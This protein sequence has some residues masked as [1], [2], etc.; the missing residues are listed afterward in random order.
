[1]AHESSRVH[2]EIEEDGRMLAAGVIERTGEDQPRVSVHREAGHLPIGTSARLID[3]VL[4]HPE[5]KNAGHITASL[6]RGDDEAFTRLRE[7]CDSVEV[8]PAGASI[9]VEAD[10]P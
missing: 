5:V 8:R 10:T 4:D 1:M 7:R 6:P 9:I 3:A 2:V